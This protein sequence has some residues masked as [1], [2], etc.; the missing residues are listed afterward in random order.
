MVPGILQT[1]AYARALLG[2]IIAF[3][4]IPDD[5]AEA[6]AARVERQRVLG[7]GHRTFAIL[8][9]ESVLWARVAPDEATAGQLGHLL[10]AMAHPR[11]SFGVIPA[12]AARPM[13]PVEGFWIFDD[14]RVVVELVTAEVTIEQPR[15]ILAHA[16]TFAALAELAVYGPRARALITAA[17]D[18]FDGGRGA[19]GPARVRA[20]RGR[21]RAASCKHAHMRGGRSRPAP[22]VVGMAETTLGGRPVA[23][24]GCEV[25][26]ALV[27]Q[28]STAW[29]AGDAG[30]AA[31]CDAELRRH[32]SRSRSRG[33][34][35]YE[36]PDAC[37]DLR[38]PC[39]RRAGVARCA[40][41]PAPGAGRPWRRGR[42]CGR[43]QARRR[44]GAAGGAA[45]P[46]APGWGQRRLPVRESGSRGQGRPRRGCVVLAAGP[47]LG[48]GPGGAGV[49]PRSGGS[50]RSG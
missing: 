9:E 20:W 2:S 18:A 44:A 49:R 31:A 30:A 40:V 46:A 47:V 17:I 10:G 16:R 15:E 4:G 50:G 42:R 43:R 34:E 38:E 1:P 21:V 19:A 39:A 27:K 5:T 14:A 33:V 7:D 36:G 48:L 23:R 29:R 22:R 28:R 24:A 32:R 45:Y 37:G 35:P 26:V 3:R 13:W 25:R 41:P 11:I 8:V 12:N 6:V